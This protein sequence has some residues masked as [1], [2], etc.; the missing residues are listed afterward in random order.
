MR[1]QRG[2]AVDRPA[3]IL[4][5]ALPMKHLS[6]V[7]QNALLP[8]FPPTPPFLIFLQQVNLLLFFFKGGN[9]GNSG[10][11]DDFAQF[12]FLDRW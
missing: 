8:P 7:G 1:R 12:Y 3:D 6:L 5:K 4:S 9:G 10:N 2:P 11:S